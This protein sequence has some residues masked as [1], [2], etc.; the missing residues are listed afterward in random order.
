MKNPRQ[1][2]LGLSMRYLGYHIAS[3]RH[4]DVPADGAIHFEYFLETARKAEAAK[5]DMVFFA[6]GV[7]VRGTDTPPG[8]LCRDMKNVELEPITLLSA[9]AACTSRIGLVATASTSYNQPFHIA[10]RFASLDQ[11]SKGRAGWN[12]V[13]SWSEN[14]ARNFNRDEHLG[15]DER[16]AMAD[17]FVD[18][19]AGLW[20]SWDEDAFIRDKSTGIFYA[21][22]K[23][24]VLDHVGPYFKVRGPLNAARTPQGRPILVQA[25]A[26]EAGR[27]IGARVADVIYSIALT[28]P[29]AQAF[30][31]DM[32]ARA[33]SFGRNPDE[34]LIM[35]GVIPYV[36]ATQAEA[37]AKL[38]ALQDLIDPITGLSELYSNF[39]D[40]SEYDIDGPVPEPRN[41]RVRSMA[42][43]LY[44]LACETNMTIRDLYRLVAAGN[45]GWTLVGTPE[46][47][48]DTLQ[49][50]FQNGAADGFNLCPATLPGGIDDVIEFILP[51]LRRRGLFR[52]EYEGRTLRANL[53]LPKP[54]FADIRR[55]KLEAIPVE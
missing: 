51:E 40:L 49:E 43:N 38:D 55:R 39:G 5:L 32:K 27:Q 18:V 24:H 36:A 35:P 15:Y 4:P 44:K 3:W 21:P 9:L 7:A 52:S 41:P 14:E 30:Y 29:Q 16:Y 28:L 54:A 45:S 11:I 13:T 33:R 19:V 2:K 48:V 6:D 53:G 37:Q 47:I 17:E 20:D 25:G 1:M 8:A 31:S 42:D 26:S 34:L 23:M 22:E 12:V 50:W 46:T 10:R